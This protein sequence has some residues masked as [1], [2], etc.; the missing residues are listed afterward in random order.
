MLL[1]D[2]V[3]FG[4]VGRLNHIAIAVQ[5][6]EAAKNFFKSVLGLTASEG[7]K[8]EEH[9]VRVSFV[10]LPNV[11]IELL[12]PLGADSPIKS[13]L[14]KNKAGGLHHL[15]FE[16]NDINSALDKIK[17]LGKYRLLDEKP[18]IGSHGTPVAFLHP[19]DCSGVLIEL[20]QV[21]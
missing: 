13:F 8:L 7:E 21:K 6:L 18:K 14:E 11:K 4:G 10:D 2:A 5:D 20:E 16:V 12:E 17:S 1:Q 19:K 15:C 3:A 9:G